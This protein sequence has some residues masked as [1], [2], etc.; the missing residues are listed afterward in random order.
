MGVRRDDKNEL[1]QDWIRQ[2]EAYDRAIELLEDQK[3][4][5]VLNDRLFGPTR[6]WEDLLYRWRDEL[7]G[8]LVQYPEEPHA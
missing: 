8:L 4:Q 3:K 7:K 1:R 2:I 6:R 5:G